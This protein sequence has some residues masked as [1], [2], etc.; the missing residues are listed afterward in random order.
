MLHGR[1]N[2]NILHKKENFFPWEKESIVPAMQLGCC[3]KPLY[4]QKP[5]GTLNLKSKQQFSESPYSTIVFAKISSVAREKDPVETSTLS[6][7]WTTCHE[8]NEHR[9]YTVTFLK[10]EIR[11][12]ETFFVILD[13][14]TLFSQG[15]IPCR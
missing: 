11:R 15:Y 12:M 7:F 14:L 2:E 10:N 4:H 3:S 6:T 1:N 8:C 13:A 5:T 9:T